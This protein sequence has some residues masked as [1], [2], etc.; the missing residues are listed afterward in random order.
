ME[1]DEVLNLLKRVSAAVIEPRHRALADHQIKEKNPGDL[2][3]VAD[4]EAEILITE[5]LQRAYPDAVI[6]GEEAT[7][8]DPTLESAPVNVEHCFTV[9]P[10]D[11]TANFVKGNDDFAVMCAELKHGQ[12]IRSWIWQPMY[13]A[14]YVG[15]RGKGV[16][17]NG[18]R[19]SV[20][21]RDITSPRVVTS[22]PEKASA[23]K[24]YRIGNTKWSCGIDYPAMITGE[25]DVAIYRGAKPWDH[26]PGMLMVTELG[27]VLIDMAGEPYLL[28][29]DYPE[30]IIAAATPQLA[31]SV[32]RD[33]AGMFAD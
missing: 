1:T 5:E 19:L 3:T 17:C 33:L 20:P 31:R 27:G 29:A 12:P 18:E 8:E 28:G 15:E 6:V 22:R 7:A 21:E 2:V 23:A 25:W 24:G 10:V 16:T 32:G 11:G 13:G 9:D 26:A 4:R 30:G 14:A